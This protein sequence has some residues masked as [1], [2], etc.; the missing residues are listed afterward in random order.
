[1]SDASDSLKKASDSLD[2]CVE[3]CSAV[4]GDHSFL[5]TINDN[6]RSLHATLLRR[7]T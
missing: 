7:P 5:E 3:R 1:M 2:S 6:L 4:S